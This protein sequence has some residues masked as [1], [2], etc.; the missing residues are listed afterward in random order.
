MSKSSKMSLKTVRNFGFE[1]PRF[2]HSEIELFLELY[3]LF[4]LSY[5]PKYS[6]FKSRSLKASF[7]ILTNWQFNNT[8]NIVAEKG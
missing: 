1:D 6:N 5:H 4:F 7:I 2:R 3:I 8:R